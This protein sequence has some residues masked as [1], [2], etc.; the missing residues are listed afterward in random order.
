MRI[1]WSKRSNIHTYIYNTYLYIYV[2]VCVCAR[3][4][5]RVCV[6]REPCHPVHE[7]MEEGLTYLPKENFYVSAL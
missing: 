3:A 1:S 7:H 5:A 4:R 2:C 6:Y